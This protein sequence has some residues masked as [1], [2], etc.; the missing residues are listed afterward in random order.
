MT[1]TK[2]RQ[3]MARTPLSLLKSTED[4]IKEEKRALGKIKCKIVT[5]NVILLILNVML[6]V[7]AA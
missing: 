5:F 1:L 2:N 4:A 3:S 7:V 6:A